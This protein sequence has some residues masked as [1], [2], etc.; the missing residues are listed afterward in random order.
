MKK[1]KKKQKS[2]QLFIAAVLLAATALIIIFSFLSNKSKPTNPD[3]Q[4]YTFNKQGELE[5]LDPNNNVV[6]KIDIEI[7]DTQDKTTQ[8]LMFRKTMEEDQGM[9]FIFDSEDYKSFW[10]KETYFS[11]DIIYANSDKEIVTIHSYTMPLAEQ[12]YPS[13]EP[14]Q[15]VV[16]VIAGFT[17]KYNIKEGYK[18]RWTKL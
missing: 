14:A 3:I 9:L 11:L 6:K 4:Y 2:K 17:K 8:G 5:F 1:S 7:A 15:Y 13:G 18:L 16:E 10:M 12:T